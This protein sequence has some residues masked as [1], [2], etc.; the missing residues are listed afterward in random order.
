MLKRVKS[1]YMKVI[2]PLGILSLLLCVVMLAVSGFGVAYMF[3]KP[4]YM[5]D[6]PLQELDGSYAY[7]EVNDLQG[8]YARFGLEA[9]D[10]EANPDIVERYCVY[11]YDDDTYMGV[12]ISGEHLADAANFFRA[13]ESMDEERVRGMDFGVLSGTVRLINDGSS[14]FLRQW[15]QNAELTDHS[16]VSSPYSATSEEDQKNAE[17][18]KFLDEHVLF[19]VLEV[20]YYGAHTQAEVY[21]LTAM[22]VVFLLVAL[23][24]L[25]SMVLGVWDKPVRRLVADSELDAIE[26]DCQGGTSIEKAKLFGEAMHVGHEN[27]W[28]LKRVKTDVLKT[29]DVVWAYPR[30]KR[31]EGGRLKWSLVLKTEDK[32]EYSICLVEGE[33]V[34]AAIDAIEAQ[35]YIL[36]TG[37][38]KLKQ[39]IYDKDI[40]AF[41]ALAKKEKKEKE[42]KASLA[43]AD[44]EQ[45]SSH[46]IIDETTEAPSDE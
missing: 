44:A 2:V 18:E 45:P 25:L 13:L 16:V 20:D 3:Q 27:I 24:L 12:R 39:K 28:W 37:Y 15:V 32:R 31:L 43:A 38:D 22:A 10:D 4:V 29:A 5:N 6:I 23:A 40:A 21:I 36:S 14:E 19:Q 34:Q 30:S 11:N 26:W 41:K 42:S 17:D 33:K 46:V 7:I 1:N 9:A 8:T 35:G